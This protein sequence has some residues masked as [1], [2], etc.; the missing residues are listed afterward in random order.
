MEKLSRLL[1]MEIESLTTIHDFCVRAKYAD[2]LSCDL[3]V[4]GD[5]LLGSKGAMWRRA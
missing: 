4:K 1:L 5:T 2:E 3:L